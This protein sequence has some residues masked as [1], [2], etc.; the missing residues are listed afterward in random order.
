M[1]T[2]RDI[3]QDADPLRH[4]PHRLEEE[5]E[6]L[7]QAVVA[8]AT[9][10]TTPPSAWLH[11]PVALLAIFALIVLGIVAVGSQTWPQGG[12]TLQAAAI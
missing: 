2:V 3:L 12:A 9:S 5:R 1:K 6:Q 4:E 7:R 10:V 11:S 8:A